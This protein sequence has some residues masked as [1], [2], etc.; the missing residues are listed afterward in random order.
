MCRGLN[1]ASALLRSNVCTKRHGRTEEPNRSFRHPFQANRSALMRRLPCQSFRFPLHRSILPVGL[2]ELIGFAPFQRSCVQSVKR[3]RHH[4]EA[5]PRSL[6]SSFFQGLKKIDRIVAKE[7]TTSRSIIHP[8]TTFQPKSHSMRLDCPS[9][10]LATY[11][12]HH[13]VF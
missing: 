13:H 7:R 4:A 5:E 6:H 2:K 9:N 10:P 11:Q 3:R 1:Q 12:Q 8:F